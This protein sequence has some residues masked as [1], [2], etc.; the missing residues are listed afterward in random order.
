DVLEAAKLSTGV[1]GAGFIENA[2]QRILVQPEGQTVTPE[3]LGEVVV[4]QS[5]GQ[6]VRLKD[7]AV[8]AE[9]GAPKFGDTLIQ[10]HSGVFMSMGSQ[11]GANTMDV[12]LA[13]E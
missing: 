2:N 12:T 5:Q 8:V 6:S 9:A 7:V 11:Y 13:V 4:S 3:A 10:G 1:V